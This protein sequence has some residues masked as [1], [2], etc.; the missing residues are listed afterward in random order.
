MDYKGK[1]ILVV[2][3][4]RSGI[5]AAKL[6]AARGALPVCQDD[7][8]QGA[9]GDKLSELYSLNCEM[10]MGESV[11]PLIDGIDAVV[12]SP[13]VPLSSPLI[14]ECKKRGIYVIGELELGFQLMNGELVAITGT[15]GKTTTTTLLGEIFKNH[16]DITHVV[17]NIGYPITAAALQSRD[18][19]IFVCEVSSFQMETSDTFH[20]RAA[21]IL[22]ITE[23]HLNRHGDMETY[24]NMKMRMFENMGKDDVAVFN[25]DDAVCRELSKRVNAKVWFFSRKEPVPAGAFV[26]DGY[27]VVRKKD[28][29]T[30]RV[31]ETTEL[32]IPGAHNLENALAAAALAFAMDIPPAVIRHTMRTFKGVE[33][34]IEFVRELWGVRYIND[35]KGTNVDASIQAVRAMERPSVIILGGSDKHSDF[36]PLVSEMKK[37]PCLKAAVTIGATAQQ[38]EAALSAQGFTQFERAADMKDAVLKCRA[39][40]SDGWNVLLSPACASFDMFS[41]YE[42][43]GRVFKEIVNSME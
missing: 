9:F 35:S 16:G 1:R 25:R 14:T 28:G 24:I 8:A 12:V 23:D 2:G 11:L 32:Q 6:L 15:N 43:R 21:A 22:N 7:R 37:N 33:H 39:F 31:C 38:I 4:A 10:H 20:P 19:D 42:Q 30:F 18:K 17:G 41:D 13:A 5:A 3:M 26:E 27:I 34:R 29:Q 40:A 36:A